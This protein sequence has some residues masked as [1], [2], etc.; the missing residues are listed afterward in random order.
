MAE[1]SRKARHLWDVVEPIAASA[2]FAP[3]AHAA[4]EQLGFQ[5]SSGEA[6]GIQFPDM[7]AYFMSRGACMGKVSGHVIAAAFGVFKREMVV[8]A[9]DAGWK[10]CS[11][12][13]PVLDA[14]ESGTVAALERVLG[15]DPPRLA[16]PTDLLRRAAD[17]APG[18]GRHLFSG[19]QSLGYPGTPMGDFWRAADL[20]REHRGD[21]HIAAWI[22][23]DLDACEIGVITDVWRGQ[24]IKSWVRSRG[25]SE[26][27]LDGAIERLRGRGLIEGDGDA[28]TAAGWQLRED[29]DTATDQMETRI[30]AALGDDIDELFRIMGP[31]AE[32][33]I[34]GRLYPAAV[35]WGQPRP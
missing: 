25:W 1:T 10:I 11:E 27:E 23:A 30:V 20:V 32:G 3:E 22:A 24:P 21:S 13:G 26:D 14:R 33:A 31:L 5:G 17:R 4:Y 6:G 12:P 19:L 2:Y 8:S 16:R 29:I 9:A 18:E 34:R 15:Q 28:I 7:V 35:T